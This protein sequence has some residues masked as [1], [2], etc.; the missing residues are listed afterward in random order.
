MNT[1][2]FTRQPIA[3]CYFDLDLAH[4]SIANDTENDVTN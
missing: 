3:H 1:E 4:V 2:V